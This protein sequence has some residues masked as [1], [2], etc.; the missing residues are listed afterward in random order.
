M[1]LEPIIGLEIHAQLKTKSKMFCSCDNSGENQPANTTVCPICLGHPGTLP[2]PN[3]A[4][5]AMAG[6]AALALHLQINQRSKFDRKNYFYPDLPK[7]YQ[8]SQYDEPISQNG[9]LDI[10]VKGETFRIG[11]ERLHI[12]EDTAKLLHGSGRTLVDFNRAGTPLIEIVSRPDLRTPEQ[13]KV[14]LQELRLILRYLGVSDADMEKGHLRCDANISLRPVGDNKLYPKT[15]VK[16]MNSFRAVER[17]LSYEIARQTELWNK[18][19]PPDTTSTRGWNEKKG[20]TVLQRTKEGEQDYRY[21]PEP[22]IPTL[23]ISQ[24]EIDKWQEELPE[25]PAARRVRLQ[26]DYGLSLADAQLLT[27]DK[28][29]GDYL[30]RVVKSLANELNEYDLRPAAKLATNWI[31]HKL[32]PIITVAGLSLDKLPVSLSQMTEF[33]LMIARHQVNS[34]NG[35]LLLKKMVTTGQE[36]SVILEQDDLGQSSGDAAGELSQVIDSVLAQYPKQVAEFKAGKE[37]LI[38]FFLGALMKETKGKADPVE[39]EEKIRQALK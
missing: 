23:F 34:T 19:A 8:I 10:A 9:Y 1:E 39:A 24:A 32:V 3:A 11:I 36:P 26:Q 13:A 25:L 12:E 31:L 29:L 14:F 33:L 18:G 21:F 5:V 4:A 28:E 15:E 38:K 37:P 27:D 20:E 35:Q 6:R 2:A 22:D 16:N 17:A 30:Q 7:G